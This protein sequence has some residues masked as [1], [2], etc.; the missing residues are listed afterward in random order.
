ME[1]ITRYGYLDYLPN[2][3]TNIFFT[4]FFSLFFLLHLFLG[5]HRRI[6]SYMLAV[7]MGVA[8]ECIGYGGRIGMYYDVFA[9]KNF[10]LYLCGLTIGPAFF[11]AAV[12][13]CIGR[14]LR[15]Y[16]TPTAVEGKEKGL[17]YLKPKSITLLFICCDTVS[18]I[19]QA[20]GGGLASAAKGEVA[21]QKGVNVMIAGLSAQVVATTLFCCVCGH[22]IWSVKRGHPERVNTETTGYRRTT[23][24]RMLLGGVAVATVTILIR[25]VFRVAELSKGF[26]SKLAN[27]EFCCHCVSELGYVLMCYRRDAI[28]RMGLNDDGDLH[29]RPFDRSSRPYPWSGPLE[30]RRHAPPGLALG[31]EPWTA[32]KAAGW[33]CC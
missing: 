12:Y 18:L 21:R 33:F 31:E 14:I 2:L 9:E 28:H 25:C 27:G 26:K 10:V 5:L 23:R 4:A 7:L 29:H 11:S 20:V 13:L 16:D 6:Y 8:L 19:L 17:T 24:F 32:G 3:P 22:L 15:V 30:G 1:C